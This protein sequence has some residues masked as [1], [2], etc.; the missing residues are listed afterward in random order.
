VGPLLEGLLLLEHRLPD[1]FIQACQSVAFYVSP[2]DAKLSRQL[3]KLTP[4]PLLT[5]ARLMKRKP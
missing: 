4:D 3:L 2:V 5:R 1:A